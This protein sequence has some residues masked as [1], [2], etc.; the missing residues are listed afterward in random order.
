MNC[1][2]FDSYHM[3]DRLHE[4]LLV[5]WER[6]EISNEQLNE[7]LDALRALYFGDE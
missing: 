3:F 5:R 2:I 6:E 7:K 1:T 4:A